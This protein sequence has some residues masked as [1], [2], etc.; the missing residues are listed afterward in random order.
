MINKNTNTNDNKD[1]N[2][3]NISINLAQPEIKKKKKYK[4]R[5]PLLTAQDRAKILG[6]SNGNFSTQT[7][8]N[9]LP[10][11]SWKQSFDFYS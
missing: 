10:K 1:N 5:K 4:K 9:Y 6:G 3:I 7:P 8:A 2:K 11:Y